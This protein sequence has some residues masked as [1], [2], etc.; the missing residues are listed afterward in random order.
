[1]GKTFI[2]DNG[3][4]ERVS[5]WITIQQNYTPN[6]NNS[7]WDYVTDEWGHNPYSDMFNR[8]GDLYLDYFRYNGNT[9]AIG[10]FYLLGSMWCSGQPIEYSDDAEHGFIT[11]VDMD[12]YYNPLYAEVDKWGEKIRLY[13]R[14]S[15]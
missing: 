14:I 8:N 12:N 10:Q 11:S 4:F 5:R 2:T 7:L 3:T 6:E 1:M 9:Y 13:R 15:D